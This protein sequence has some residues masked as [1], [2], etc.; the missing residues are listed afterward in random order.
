[1]VHKCWHDTFFAGTSLIRSGNS[2]GLMC[3]VMSPFLAF[4][5]FRPGHFRGLRTGDTSPLPA[6]RPCGLKPGGPPFRNTPEMMKASRKSLQKR[7]RDL[8]RPPDA[9][10]C[11]RYPG[12]GIGPWTLPS[13]SREKS[14]MPFDL[15]KQ[16]I[17]SLRDLIQRDFAAPLKG[18]SYAIK[19]KS[20]E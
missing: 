5:A 16:V 11:E 1:M 10:T 7:H 19:L 20:Y 2:H 6:L 3:E 9:N 14:P 8:F 4:Q 13:R 15:F 12:I 18:I 17:K